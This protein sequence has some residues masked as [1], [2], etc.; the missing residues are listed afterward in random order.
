MSTGGGMFTVFVI[1]V[2]VAILV[3]VIAKVMSKNKSIDVNDPI[4]DK[5]LS[6]NAK[7]DNSIK[8]TEKDKDMME[9]IHEL[10]VI[11]DN[12]DKYMKS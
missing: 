11:Y 10:S 7:K 8:Y 9:L 1:V 5:I 3:I 2:I 12:T 4:V 6:P